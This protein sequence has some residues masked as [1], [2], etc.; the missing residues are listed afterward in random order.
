MYTNFGNVV[1]ACLSNDN[2]PLFKLFPPF[3]DN[4]KKKDNKDP[5]YFLKQEIRAHYQL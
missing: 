4:N 1:R 2:V 3:S 5:E